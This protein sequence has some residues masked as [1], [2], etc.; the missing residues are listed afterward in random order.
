MQATESHLFPC[1]Q[2]TSVFH[3]LYE[4]GVILLECEGLVTI[5]KHIFDGIKQILTRNLNVLRGSHLAINHYNLTNAVYAGTRQHRNIC[6]ALWPELEGFWVIS[7]FIYAPTS[8]SS[9][10]KTKIKPR[11]VREHNLTP[12][13][14]HCPVSGS[15]GPCDPE[16][17]VSRPDQRFS[18]GYSAVVRSCM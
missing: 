15:G 10:I 5:S 12:I 7:F 2:S 14:I 17:P 3:G 16:S 8:N 18:P 11:F 4:R 6:G 9:I 1:H 13:I